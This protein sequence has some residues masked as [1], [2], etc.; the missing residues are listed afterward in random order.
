M[1]SNDRSTNDKEKASEAFIKGHALEWNVK[2]HFHL[3][4]VAQKLHAVHPY[5]IIMYCSKDTHNWLLF[6]LCW[7]S[8]IGFLFYLI[9]KR[10]DLKKTF[11]TMVINFYYEI[12]YVSDVNNKKVIRSI[13]TIVLNK[14]TLTSLISTFSRVLKILTVIQNN[15][16]FNKFIVVHKIFVNTIVWSCEK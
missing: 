4:T 1:W 13:S 5:I 7:Q 14:K 16:Y 3:E 8:L 2:C 10:K 6:V 12:I 9:W 15:A 11:V